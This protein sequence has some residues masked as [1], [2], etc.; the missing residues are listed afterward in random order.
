VDEMDEF[1]E[2]EMTEDNYRT[3]FEIESDP[4]DEAV[5]IS[6]YSSEE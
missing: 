6:E 2:D 5:E 3:T 4:D 1:N